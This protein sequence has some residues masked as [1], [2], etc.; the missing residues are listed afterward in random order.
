MAAFRRDDKVRLRWPKQAWGGEAQGR[1]RVKAPDTGY[2]SRLRVTARAGI[3]H[4]VTLGGVA[5]SGK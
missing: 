2:G 1:G 3:R 4:V 5:R